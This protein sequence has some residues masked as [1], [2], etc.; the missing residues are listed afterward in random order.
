MDTPEIFWDET[1]KKQDLRVGPQFNNPIKDDEQWA[2][3]IPTNV[4]GEEF[5][6]RYKITTDASNS[7]YIYGDPDPYW[8]EVPESY[9]R[10][11]AMNL[12]TFKNT[13]SSRRKNTVDYAVDKS[14]QHTIRW[15]N[16]STNEIAFIDYIV[17]VGEN[18]NKD[19]KKEHKWTY[20]LDNIV[21]HRYKSWEKCPLWLKCIDEWFETDDK[22]LALQEFMGYVLCSH[23][24]FK[25][26]L[27]LLGESNSGKSVPCDIMKE[28]I[29]SMYTCSIAPDRMDD[30]K[31]V[32]EI[33]GKKLN[34]ITELS[35]DSMLAD[36]GFKKIISGEPTQID[37]KYVA[38]Q[39]IIPV[40][41]HIIATNNLPRIR[42]SSAGV[43][44]RLLIIK[45]NKVVPKD[46]QNPDLTNL[47]KKEISGIIAWAVEGLRRLISNKGQFTEIKES[48]QI[49]E[50]YRFSQNPLLSF[51]EESDLLEKDP[52]ARVLQDEF[53]IRFQEYKGGKE[54]NKTTIGRM[55]KEM[56]YPSKSSNSKRY[57][58]G[59]RFKKETKPSSEQG[60]VD[61]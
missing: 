24:K 52:N 33:K 11:L 8:K 56:G 40:A 3:K 19:L 37:K 16:L 2:S 14:F 9:L 29:G 15:N 21:P 26:A 41:K 12:D 43:Y 45:F 22:K 47:L 59:L 60:L 20:Y 39:T 61:F 32:A 36:G 4:L 18:K 7:K 25:K 53:R 35:S 38:V 50:D 42:D 5:L 10:A 57:Y 51:I 28:I 55:M 46:Q 6:K 17:E 44:N 48:V 30:P 13:S 23:V 54:F 34:L 1:E 31:A 49:I 58:Q 27:L